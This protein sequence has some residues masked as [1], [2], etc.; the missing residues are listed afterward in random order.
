[1]YERTIC[2]KK[3]S[4]SGK[5][6]TKSGF[7]AKIAPKWCIIRL[8]YEVKREMV[9]RESKL[10]QER[11]RRSVISLKFF[12]QKNVHVARKKR[13]IWVTFLTLDFPQKRE[14][15]HSVVFPC[16]LICKSNPVSPTI[17]LLLHMYLFAPIRY[18]RQTGE[19]CLYRRI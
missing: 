2:L 15:S 9:C 3:S 8:E 12:L 14:K 1:M 4:D 11:R 13:Y 7:Q 18:R 6:V 10:I 19:G 17:F 5:K 16:P